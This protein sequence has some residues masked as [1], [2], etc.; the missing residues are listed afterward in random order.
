MTPL[1]SSALPVF[2]STSINQGAVTGVGGPPPGVGFGGLVGTGVASGGDVGVGLFVGA[3]VF[4]GGGFVAAGGA[5]VALAGG[6]VGAGPPPPPPGLRVGLGVLVGGRG[7]GGGFPPP[8]VCA[9]GVSV[10]VG[11]EVSTTG[12]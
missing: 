5:E 10:R 11:V 2:S 12:M 1:N 6:F 7:V 9:T 8:D 4:V 3:L